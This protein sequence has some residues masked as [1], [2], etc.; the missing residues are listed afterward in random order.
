M[1]K[2]RNNVRADL[3]PR[4]EAANRNQWPKRVDGPSRPTRDAHAQ[5]VVTVLGTGTV[6]RLL[7]P[8]T[9]TR[10]GVV[11]VE[12][13]GGLRTPH[14]ARWSAVE[15][16]GA[17]R[18]CGGGISYLSGGVPRRRTRVVADSGSDKLLWHLRGARV[19]SHEKVFEES[20]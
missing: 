6:A 17:T 8:G 3:G 1:D 13:T 7:V 18:R 15:L 19:M 12:S 10:W 14:W 20:D 4:L 2:S 9:T 5:C 16:T 11:A